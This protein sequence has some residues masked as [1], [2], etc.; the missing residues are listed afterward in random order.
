MKPSKNPY[1]T[2]IILALFLF[3]PLVLII[4]S[5]VVSRHQARVALHEAEQETFIEWFGA[6]EVT[7]QYALIWE[8]TGL[9]GLGIL[10]QEQI[11]EILA[12]D[13][14]KDFRGE[15]SISDIEKLL[16]GGFPILDESR[17]LAARFRIAVSDINFI[18]RDLEID[19]NIRRSWDD[20]IQEYEQ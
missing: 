1:K 14:Y 11:S 8:E 5:S 9:L 19:I 7:Y 20:L 15:E 12:S 3:S 2:S 18:L 6:N 17:F 16:T 4:I 13:E 10:S